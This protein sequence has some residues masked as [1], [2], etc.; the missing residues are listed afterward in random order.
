MYPIHIDHRTLFPRPSV[1]P[2]SWAI[3]GCCG[4]IM[5]SVAR[6]LDEFLSPTKI[7]HPITAEKVE[8][9]RIHNEVSRIPNKSRRRPTAVIR[10]SS[11]PMDPNFFKKQCKIGLTSRNP[12][13]SPRQVNRASRMTNASD[14]RRI[15]TETGVAFIFLGT[16]AAMAFAYFCSR[17]IRSQD[18]AGLALGHYTFRN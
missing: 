11:N 17:L 3:R 6:S 2:K 13:R 7:T 9:K 12:L 5:V 8:P 10:V 1:V 15:V 14:S 18:F 4:G 16:T